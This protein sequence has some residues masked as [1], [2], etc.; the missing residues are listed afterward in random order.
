MTGTFAPRT[1]T[2]RIKNWR[3]FTKVLYVMRGGAWLYRGQEDASW[4]L[5]SSLDR[6]LEVNSIDNPAEAERSN[7]G[8]FMAN[9]KL[10]GHSWESDIDALIA[11][12]HHEAKTRLVDFSTSLM[13]ALFFAFEKQY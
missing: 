7:I 12:Q 2:L 13:V 4:L 5:Q 9:S 1:V 3:D 8:L 6:E 10:L 11:M